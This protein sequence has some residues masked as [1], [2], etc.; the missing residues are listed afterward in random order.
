MKMQGLPKSGIKLGDDCLRVRTTAKLYHAC[1]NNL[2]FALSCLF[3]LAAAIAAWEKS[4]SMQADRG[5]LP[6]R[7]LL[8][9]KTKS[10]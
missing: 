3:L 9:F 7:S 4:V 5:S 10:P 8:L 1:K 6:W 2:F